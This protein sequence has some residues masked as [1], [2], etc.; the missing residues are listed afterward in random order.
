MITKALD[1]IVRNKH[2]NTYTEVSNAC[3]LIASMTDLNVIRE[4]SVCPW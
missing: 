3:L 1:K 4:V 2:Y